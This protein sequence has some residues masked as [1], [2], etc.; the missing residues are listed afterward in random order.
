MLEPILNLPR[1]ASEDP[2]RAKYR[3]DIELPKHM[4]SNTEKDEPRRAKDRTDCEAP[5]FTKSKIERPEPKLAAAYILNF[6]PK[7][8]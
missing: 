1:T 3:I 7:R 2:K 6:D 8:A 4:L 5:R